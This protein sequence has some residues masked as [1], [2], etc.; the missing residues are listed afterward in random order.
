MQLRRH[1]IRT[2]ELSNRRDS[3]SM[4]NRPDCILDQRL[5]GY[6]RMYGTRMYRNMCEGVREREKGIRPSL[7]W[8]NG[9]SVRHWFRKRKRQ[10]YYAS[11]WGFNALWFCS[12]PG[13]KI[14]TRP[15]ARSGVCAVCAR[16]NN[17]VDIPEETSV[18]V[19][20]TRGRTG[21]GEAGQCSSVFEFCPDSDSIII[22][23]TQT[24]SHLRP[25]RSLFRETPVL[26]AAPSIVL[27]LP[28]THFCC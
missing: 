19:V 21:H 1:A 4:A 10:G 24:P 18:W 28:S 6:T 12:A 14:S 3:E 2:S 25:S 17:R 8:Q 15:D 26:L 22:S 7:T 20:T 16:N 5:H 13:T 11:K 27:A 23:I 9:W